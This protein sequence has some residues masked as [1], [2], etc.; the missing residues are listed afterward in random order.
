MD[1]VVCPDCGAE[2]DLSDMEPSYQ[3]PDAY[4]AVPVEER[5]FRTLPSKDACGVRD[6]EDIC[7]QY[8]LRVSLPIPVRGEQEPCSWGVLVEIDATANARTREL[9]DD[10]EQHKE[11]QF[12]GTLANALK[13]Y[14]HT[15]GLEGHVQLTGPTSVPTF[16]LPLGLDHPLA[17]EQRE[18]VFP[19]RV[20]EWLAQ[21]CQH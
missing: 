3:W 7:R 20:V 12:Q 6:A 1:R 2:Y 9:W 4:L 5:A 8:F 17:I 13:G 19:E 15:M 16:T 10:P 11:P 14:E 21:H 18:G